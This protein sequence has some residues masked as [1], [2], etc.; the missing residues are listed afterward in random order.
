MAVWWIH[1]AR[2]PRVSLRGAIRGWLIL[3]GLTLAT[4]T[5]IHMRGESSWPW[6][7]GGSS[8]AQH[9]LRYELILLVYAVYLS[10][11]SLPTWLRLRRLLQMAGASLEASARREDWTAAALH[12]HR[13]CLHYSAL[14]RH[15]PMTAEAWDLIIREHVSQHRRLYVYYRGEPPPLPGDPLSGF[16]PKE[17]PMGRP[18]IW[19]LLAMLPAGL[20]I[21]AILMDIWLRAAWERLL[22]FNVL[23][24]LAVFL[25][26][27]GFQVIG[28]L[29]RHDCLRL[30]PGVAQWVK[31]VV[32][33]VEPRVE[34]FDVRRG[35]LSLDL[36]G[37]VPT[38]TL[39][40][41]ESGRC[42]MFR[43]PRGGSDV[44]ETVLRMALSSAQVPPLVKEQVRG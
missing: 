33:R 14:W 32:F 42:E 38:M 11:V 16:A 19:S 2:G 28:W 29:G 41:R 25:V 24:M 27:S 34:T 9:L 37:A 21:Y 36:T 13:Y 8:T 6:A 39:I 40:E 4:L 1:R 20:L 3:L 30:A 35:D 44:V 12:L 43:L 18:S 10:A 26:V 17:L 15:V 5:W 22:V 7:P 31:H 23:A